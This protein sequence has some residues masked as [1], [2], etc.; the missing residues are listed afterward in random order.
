MDEELYM[1][2]QRSSVFFCIQTMPPLNSIYF[3][4]YRVHTC[5]FFIFCCLFFDV[6]NSV[7]QQ[8]HRVGHCNRI[9]KKAFDNSKL[10]Y[11]LLAV[12]MPAQTKQ[13]IMSLYYVYSCT[14]R[15]RR[16]T[17]IHVYLDSKWE[18]VTFAFKCL[19][20]QMQTL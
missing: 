7:F 20:K 17:Y 2:K 18:H 8:I 11:K 6:A 12:T 5:S 19:H 14:W 3:H 15:A 10:M 9:I 16:G 4:L 1:E 13:H